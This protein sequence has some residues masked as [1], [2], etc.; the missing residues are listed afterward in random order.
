MGLADRS[1]LCDGSNPFIEQTL[2]DTVI[3][4]VKA[5]KTWLPSA[6]SAPPPPPP[7]AGGAVKRKEHIP[8]NIPAGCVSR[9][10]AHL[11][12]ES[13]PTSSC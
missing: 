2:P 7:A 5:G 13:G 12:G 1:E 8:P 11:P 10:P 4:D 6:P 9:I 3:G